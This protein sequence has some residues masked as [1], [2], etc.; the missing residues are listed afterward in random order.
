MGWK[1]GR[2]SVRS[3]AEKFHNNCRILFNLDLHDFIDFGVVEN[4]ER[5]RI[6]WLQFSADPLKAMLKMGD[7]R[8]DA[9]W[10]LIESRQP[11]GKTYV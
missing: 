2:K 7:A 6:V 4:N 11:K 9:L 8:Y 10:A 5:G 3:D 1:S